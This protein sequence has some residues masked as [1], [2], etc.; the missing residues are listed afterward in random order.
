MDDPSSLDDEALFLEAP[1]GRIEL[2][3]FGRSYYA[4]YFGYAGIDI[5]SVLTREDL[6]RAE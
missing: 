6:S 1:D 5:R 3:D 2:T 4:P